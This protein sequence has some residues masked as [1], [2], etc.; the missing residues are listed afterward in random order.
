MRQSFAGEP[1]SE[2]ALACQLQIRFPVLSNHAFFATPA[3]YVIESRGFQPNLR[4]GSSPPPRTLP[5]AVKSDLINISRD[6]LQSDHTL[7]MLMHLL[8]IVISPPVDLLRDILPLLGGFRQEQ[9]KV[10]ALA[11]V[12][13]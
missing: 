6:V 10:T 12:S 1:L 8:C 5:S 2:P 13:S 3:F 7:L 4:R 9:A 11:W